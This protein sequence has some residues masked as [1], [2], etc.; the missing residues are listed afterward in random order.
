[1][2]RYDGKFLSGVTGPVNFRPYRGQQLVQ[3][4]AQHIKHTEA[5]KK[6]SAT[7]G[8]SG[9][10]ASSIRM[11]FSFIMHGRQDGEL[12]NRL[13]SRVALILDSTR[14]RDNGEY[15]FMEDSF[16][17]L[18]GLDFTV[19][20]PIINTLRIIPK[21]V[22]LDNQLTVSLR[23]FK[24]PEQLKFPKEAGSCQITFCTLLYNLEK[25]TT[26]VF[27]EEHSITLNQY[28]E[29]SEVQEFSFHVPDGTLAL[30][31]IFLDFY[32][33]SRDFKLLYNTKKWYPASICAAVMAPGEF[34]EDP[35]RRF[36]N[37]NVGVA[38]S[39]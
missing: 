1:M 6:C 21:W 15:D 24:I 26:A 28:D 22:Y 18:L 35:E 33:L 16:D 8:K 20:S 34:K 23:R 12:Y 10:F 9:Q 3:I 37:M 13:N 11:K 2:A 32:D 14:N 25:G 5:T 30:T 4:K 27:P 36:L 19:G 7:F 31:G 38:K 29:W 39:S 17:L